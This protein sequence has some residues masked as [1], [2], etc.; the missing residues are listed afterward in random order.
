MSVFKRASRAGLVVTAVAI[1]LVLA[2]ASTALAAP[3][4]Q[5]LGL[6]ALKAK[7]DASGTVE[8]YLK[9]VVK[10]SDITTIPVTV[11]GITDGPLILFEA[12]GPLI[13]KYGGIVA[14]MSGSPIYVDDG[15]T[16]KVI[17]ALSYGDYDTLGGTGEATPI[18]NMLNIQQKYS[19][20]IQELDHPVITRSGVISRILITNTTQME[21][22]A[23]PYGVAVAHPLTTPV[24]IG[25]VSPTSRMFKRAKA[26][27]AKHNIDLI[28][29]N[30]GVSTS[31]NVGDQSFE[32]TFVPGASLSAL[33]GRGDLLFGSIGTVTYTD[34][35]T[36]LAYGHPESQR[37]ASDIYM[38]NAWI[39]G[40]WPST[41][42][43]YKVG[44]IGAVRGAITQDRGAGIMGIV[45]DFP[46]ETTITATATNADNPTETTT[47]ATYMPRVLLNTIP[48]GDDYDQMAS[49]ILPSYAA[50]EAGAKLF[51]QDHTPGSAAVTTTVLVRDTDH[52]KLYTITMPNFVSDDYDIPSAIVWNVDDAV[53]SLQQELYDDVYHFEILSVDVTSRISAHQKSA[54]IVGLDV[55]NA[56]KVGANPVTVSFLAFG[57][58]ATQTANA[59]ITIP[60]GVPTNGMLS[61]IASDMGISQFPSVDASGN[62]VTPI[63]YSYRSTI[64]NIVNQL[65]SELPGNYLT[66]RYYVSPNSMSD[67]SNMVDGASAASS[68][69]FAATLKAPISLIATVPTPWAVDGVASK[70][71]TLVALGL[72][73]RV[74]DYNGFDVLHGMI[75]DGADDPGTISLYGKPAG[76]AVESLLGTTTADPDDGYSFEFDLEGM[77]VN[78]LLRVHTVAVDGYLAEDTTLTV[79]VHAALSFST[80]ASSVTAGKSV[81]LS[82]KVYPAANAGAK[83]TFEFYSRGTWHKI[84]TKTLSG[85]SAARASTAWKVPKGT[86][87][88]RFRFL[89]SGYNVATTSSTKSVKGN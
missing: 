43:P 19:L 62:P 71:P 14:G 55:P 59:T 73:N 54:T 15:G 77:H 25:G 39:D 82:A 7:L 13:Q 21:P 2:C 51:D 46:A 12:T 10:G 44:R 8:G 22:A 17:G 29:L 3:S 84:A 24:F 87:K 42:E 57:L 75:V 16:D 61:A 11:L 72:E 32:T 9:T 35:D 28:A 80:S 83:V 67:M 37:G 64:A 78:T 45:G 76:S 81:T 36:V 31:P 30:K 23:T 27:F 68:Q 26:I 69:A 49:E 70:Y 86:Y 74:M 48:T 41:A 66:L 40:I 1:V 58:E 79:P 60:A 85:G 52:D 89:G 56:L 88:V 50:Y 65:N 18:E 47:S 34:S 4:D 20:G 33:E 53:M 63:T 5:T 38:A 6:T